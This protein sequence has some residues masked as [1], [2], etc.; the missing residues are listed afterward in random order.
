MVNDL[1]PLFFDQPISIFLAAFI[2]KPIQNCRRTVN[3]GMAM[4]QHPISKD[5]VFVFNKIR[6]PLCV[7]YVER[8][9]ERSPNV[10]DERTKS[11]WNEVADVEY[12]SN[13]V[14]QD[15]LWI[16]CVVDIPNKQSWEYLRRRNSKSLYFE[17]VHVFSK[18]PGGF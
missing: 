5:E 15:K 9:S 8:D 13:L 6:N 18:K 10:F 11:L 1:R 4:E 2:K 7:V 12:S 16:P 3:A 14:L 17:F